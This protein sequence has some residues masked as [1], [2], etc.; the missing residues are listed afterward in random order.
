MYYTLDGK[1]DKVIITIPKGGYIPQ[2]HLNREEVQPTDSQSSLSD[3]HTKSIRIVALP[4][5]DLSYDKSLDFCA[6]AISEDLSSKLSD[7]KDFEVV[8]HYSAHHI[9]NENF[10][11]DKIREKYGV[12]HLITGSVNV[13]K[14][15][16]IYNVNLIESKTKTQLWSTTYKAELNGVNKYEILQSVT[17]KIL[18][19]IGGDYGV[20]NRQLWKSAAHKEFPNLKAR[21][22][23]FLYHQYQLNVSMEKLLASEKALNNA[24][25]E[26]P[27]F[28]LGWATLGEIHVDYYSQ[29]YDN[30]NDHLLKAGDFIKR[31][32]HLDP[33]LQYGFYVL[34]CLQLLERNFSGVCAT[35]NQILSLNPNE[36]YHVGGAAFFMALAG[37]YDRGL[38]FIKKSIELN[39][40]YPTYFHHAF[41]LDHISKREFELANKEALRFFNP[42]FFWSHLD[43][44]ATY[45]LLGK[46]QEAEKS[47]SKLLETNPDFVN[48]PLEYTSVFVP[49][50]SLLEQMMIGLKRAG[51]K[52]K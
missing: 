14:G 52:M 22:A 51:L 18:A 28:A 15:Q 30:R 48:H 44:A 7:F 27:E 35:F 4:F 33:C 21:E 19:Y 8:S 24:V 29:L 40:Y 23:V 50:E 43:H 16:F 20:I 38:Q 25:A 32:I 37:E 13:L 9:K 1:D 36:A 5:M 45:G 39:P 6:I 10:S 47:L 31:A 46:T 3:I 41:M 12:T 26:D 42:D 49:Q 34:A 17:G 2:F 11:I